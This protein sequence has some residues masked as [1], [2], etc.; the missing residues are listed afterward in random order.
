MPAPPARSGADER[1][2]A[3][4]RLLLGETVVVAGDGAGA[5]VEIGADMGIADI[6]EIVDLGARLGSGVRIAAVETM[7]INAAEECQ[8]QSLPRRTL[9][10]PRLDCHARGIPAS[11]LSAGYQTDFV[12]YWCCSTG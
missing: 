5:E 7:M 4:Q 11:S 10:L 3:D 12:R 2:L 1:A 6:G 8:P 9:L